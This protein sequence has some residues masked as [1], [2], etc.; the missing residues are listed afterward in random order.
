MGISKESIRNFERLKGSIP[1]LLKKKNQIIIKGKMVEKKI[2]NKL[3][4]I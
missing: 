2:C 1:N 4:N 3:L